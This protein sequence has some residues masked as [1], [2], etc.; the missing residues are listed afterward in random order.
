MLAYK[1]AI[2]NTL[3]P[4][5]YTN[6]P[7]LDP[8]THPS[9]AT[10]A[11]ELEW[12]RRAGRLGTASAHE[13]ENDA[14]AVDAMLARATAANPAGWFASYHAY[15]YY[16]DFMLHDPAYQD[17]RSRE[18]RSN[19]F[20][21]LKELQRHHAG[22]PLVIAE[23]GV[24]SSRGVAH[25]QPQG[26]NHGGHDERAMAAIDAR[27][28]R[29]I[30]ESG[31]AGGILFSWMDE[32]FKRNWLVIDFEIPLEN[33]RQWSNV[34]DAEQHY[35]LLGHY[36]GRAGAAPEPGG[37]AARWLALPKI[38]SGTG[39]LKA[40][41]A[42]SDPA[43]VYLAV[44]LPEPD[45]AREGLEIGIDTWLRGRGQHRLPASG[46]TGDVGFEFA[47]ELPAP[48]SGAVRVA[49]D[50]NRYALIAD[51][52]SGSDYGHFYHRPVSVTDRRDG[53]FDPMFVVT[54]RSRYGRDGT[55]FP[56][57]GV[58]RGQLRFG[59]E[60][61]ST[62]S[63]WYYDPAARLLELR[64][65][66]DLLNVTDPSTRTLLLDRTGEGPFGTVTAD[67]FHFAVARYRKG[68]HAVT[69]TVAAA[70]WSWT[71]WT[72]P[73]SHARLKPAADSMRAVWSSL[74]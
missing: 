41:R 33:T 1:D 52:A 69:G 56:A 51:L 54:N 67:S 71:G 7:T 62:L 68:S 10:T 24:P 42:G 60:S 70:P 36:A 35:G 57:A 23:Y 12:R 5:A 30:H 13:Y 29:E 43:Y 32:W 16:P 72:S 25:L 17:A 14:V 28:T 6:W 19:Y 4:I 3:R 48:D 40:L 59:T 45:W 9:E 50:Y 27:L 44:E 8:L 21:Y 46:L 11:E 74:P 22:M 65:P 2:N 18:G 39:T 66:W 26:W 63:D 55:F 61:G 49:P 64:L 47:V 15:P 37:E 34:M 38:G 58:D 31:A 20:G 53:R 73:V